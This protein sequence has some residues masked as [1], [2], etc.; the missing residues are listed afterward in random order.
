[1]A[2]FTFPLVQKIYLICRKVKI[3]FLFERGEI[4][5]VHKAIVVQ[6]LN[7]EKLTTLPKKNMFQMK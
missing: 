2:S 5:M 7:L 4:H 6:K 3:T 1:M